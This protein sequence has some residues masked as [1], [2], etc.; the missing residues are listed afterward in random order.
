VD[1]YGEFCALT[2]AAEV[3]AD[4][5]TPLIVRELLAGHTRFNDLHRRLPRIS[6]SILSDRLRRLEREGI[7][8]RR[9]GANG[10][11][12]AYVL[13]PAGREAEQVVASL[14]EWG[15]KWVLGEPRPQD[16]DPA[17][18]LW[19]MRR[20]IDR[21]VLPEG[22]V[23]VEFDFSGARKDRLW[24][25]LERE[26]V[27]VCLHHPGFDEDLIVRADVET[28]FQVWLGRIDLE[29]ALDSETVRI[30]GPPRLARAFTGWV[31]G[32]HIVDAVKTATRAS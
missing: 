3:L 1:P 21:T 11:T 28:M 16:L 24:L 9:I 26:D 20:R 25:V 12:S 29:E 23:V 10:R 31:L 7:V 32:S 14:R 18:V 15:K 2:L 5:W 19:W 6:R 27:S 4:R 8:Y 22:R 30:E 13:T 17:L